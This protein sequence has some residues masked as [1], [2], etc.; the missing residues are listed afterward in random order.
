MILSADNTTEDNSILTKISNLNSYYF[1]WKLPNEMKANSV[2][3]EE[4]TELKETEFYSREVLG[5]VAQDLKEAFPEFVYGEESENEYLTIDYAGL[6]AVVAVEGL[7]ELNTKLE[8]RV[9]YLENRL[10]LVESK[11]S[12]NEETDTVVS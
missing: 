6:G 12:N 3:D 10:A 4:E 5:F 11:L 7:K 8:N 1:N 2:S 9:A